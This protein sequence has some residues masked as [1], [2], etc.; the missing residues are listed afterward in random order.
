MKNTIII[1]LIISKLIYAQP[2]STFQCDSLV[3]TE[4]L[5]LNG[6]ENT[7]PFEKYFPKALQKYNDRIVTIKMSLDTLP[8][9]IYR[10]SMLSSLE[11]NYSFLSKIPDSIGFLSNL[12]YLVLEGN[13]LTTI[14]NT[15]GRL[16]NIEWLN[17]MHNQ[18]TTLPDSI[19]HLTN[20]R[21]VG[22][23]AG[24]E[25][26]LEFNEICSLP[27]AVKSWAD[28][29]C[30]G[31]EITQRCSTTAAIV[32]PEPQPVSRPQYNTN[33]RL[34]DIQGWAVFPGREE[35]RGRGEVPLLLLDPVSRKRVLFMR[36]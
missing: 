21:P 31:W 19:V 22:D 16:E 6:A 17:L 27:P 10:L 32:L 26:R 33:H 34:Y 7:L 35:R 15:I 4:L 20:L 28:K 11:I 1:A 9:W 23:A 13:K 8:N 36:E 2:C 3:I 24:Y 30:P 29:M 5:K 18:L 12:H 25:C 14:P